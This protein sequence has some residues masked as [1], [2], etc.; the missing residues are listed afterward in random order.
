MLDRILGK[1]L[2][3]YIKDHRRLIL[4]ALF[5]TLI[6]TIVSMVPLYIIKMVIQVGV[7]YHKESIPVKIPWISYIAGGFPPFKIT[8][9][10]ILQKIAP[11]H[12]LGILLVV[13]AVSVVIKSISEY[14]SGLLTAAFTH[15]SIT[16]MRIDLFDNFMR[17]HQA[18]YHKHKIGNLISR[19]TSDLAQM[20]FSIA[21]IIIGLIQY[22]LL[23]L[24]Y[25]IFL[26]YMDWKLTLLVSFTGPVIVGLTRLF[27]RKVKKHAIRMQDATAD[28]TSTYQESM[29]CLKVIQGFGAEKI[30]SNKFR[31][32]AMQL[33]KKIMH[34][35]RWQLGLG[36][37]M[38]A[39]STCVALAILAIA[40]TFFKHS[41]SDL[42]AIFF[43]FTRLYS[44]IKNLS[45][46][47]NDLRTLQ[48][49][50]QRVFGIMNAP[51]EIRDRPGAIEITAPEESVEFK[52]VHFSYASGNEVLKD[53]SFKVKK[54]EIVAFVGSTGAGKSTLIDLIPRFYDVTAG[55][56]SIDGID[57][58]NITLQSLRKQTGIVNQEVLLFHDTVA[59]NISF[60]FPDIGKE[61][62]I[63]AAKKAH[64]HD[65]ITGLSDGYETIVGDRGTMLSGGQKQRISIARAILMNTSILILDEVASA[66]DAESEEL[67][68]KSIDALKGKCTIFMIAHR[69]STIRNADRIFVLE[70]GR[71]IE[72]GTQQELLNRNGRFRQLYDM[73]FHA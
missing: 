19:S 43:A 29:L 24:G 42:G 37:L 36:P 47:N 31:E 73:Q 35:S 8:E 67:I 32:T 7:D 5:F 56:I 61:M 63:E 22:P 54:G 27:G 13:Y 6:F 12:F 55:S 16:A 1:E 59:N 71:I 64:A 17:L 44:P 51:S 40:F 45:K 70:K 34:W 41:A 15:R 10:T 50:T 21:N 58:K 30:Q 14:T 65:F 57:I 53:I 2:A 69:L 68:Y 11:V 49:A 60:G 23:I 46:V 20:Q 62:I 38:E 48:G 18:F 66:L 26:F 72:S 39:I 52:N 9:I 4:A 3:F 28:V 33:Y 25:F